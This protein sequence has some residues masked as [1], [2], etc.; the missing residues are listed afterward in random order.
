MI[1]ILETQQFDR[2]LLSELFAET[3]RLENNS[4]TFL[5]GKIMASLFYEPSTRTRFSFESAMHRLGGAV[6]TT[7]NATEFSSVS[8]GE[9]IEDSIRVVNHYADVVVLRHSEV[10]MAARAAA[11]ADIPIINAGDGPGQH[12]TQALLDL[13]TI[14]REYGSIDGVH[15][16]MAG[17]LLHGRTVHSLCYLLGKYD[18]V[19]ITFVS[20]PHLKIPDTIKQ[21]LQKHAVHVTETDALDTVATAADVIYQTRIQK[22]RFAS[23]AEY[24]K[25]VGKFVLGMEL[26]DRMKHNAIIMHP[27]PR[28]DEISSEVDVSPK[29]VYF[30]QAGYGVP[31]R[32]ALLKY[33]FG[34]HFSI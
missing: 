19:R 21:Y 34:T 14:Q 2:I 28:V 18:D 1:H 8:K 9:T 15:V 16:V 13:Y 32:M 20:L 17:D 22:E 4:E 7:E 5:Q 26:V 33:I 29:A 12:P 6:I 11:V 10:G 24:K 25:S 30:K 3:T 31:V 27:L 23:V